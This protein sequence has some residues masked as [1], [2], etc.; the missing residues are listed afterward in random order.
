MQDVGCA[1]GYGVDVL[2]SFGYDACG[3]DVSKYSVEKAKKLCSA[4]F[5]VCDVQKGFPSKNIFDLLGTKQ[6]M[7]ILAAFSKDITNCLRRFIPW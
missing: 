4:D 3:V 6:H 1:Y 2:E 7:A 5:V